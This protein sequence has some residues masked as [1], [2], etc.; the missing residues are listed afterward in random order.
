MILF[1]KFYFADA[2]QSQPP[3]GI[4]NAGASINADENESFSAVAYNERGEF[5]GYIQLN[6]QAINR[7][8]AEMPI[9]EMIY[10]V[11]DIR[12]VLQTY[13]SV[14]SYT[15][16]ETVSHSDLEKISEYLISRG[17]AGV[18]NHRRR[19]RRQSEYTNKSGCTFRILTPAPSA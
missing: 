5:L 2:D 15:F 7:L 16:V 9:E 3:F 12:P 8:V 11:T 10:L 13:S 19:F 6:P 14:G 18:F 4:K 1:K 17:F